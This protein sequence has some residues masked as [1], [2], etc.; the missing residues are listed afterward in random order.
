LK[1]D[2]KMIVTI[3][4]PN[5]IPYIGY[6][7]KA[8]KSDVFV[9]YDIAQYTKNDFINRNKIKTPHGWTWLTIP[10]KKPLTRSINEIEIDNSKKWAKKHW[11]AIKSSYGRCENFSEYEDLFNEAFEKEWTKLADINEYFLQSIFKILC[12]KV[13]FKKASELDIPE[14]L[15]PTEMLIEITKKANG[16]IYLS[17]IDGRKYLDESKFTEPKLELIQFEHPVYQQKFNEFIPNLSI[18][19]LLF[20]CGE[21][22]IKLISESV[23]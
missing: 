10:V 5:Y 3:H 15:D 13:E 17:G 20:N 6:F 18:I 12:P 21:E 7:A 1:E 11:L 14:D 22:S 4:Q 16:D 2:I 23:K 19:D 9:S 8:A